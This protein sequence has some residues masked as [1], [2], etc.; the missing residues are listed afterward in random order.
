MA[1]EDSVTESI[2]VSD[3]N[4]NLITLNN[5][6]TLLARTN[7][8]EDEVLRI[9]TATGALD[10]SLMP[11]AG[12]ATDATTDKPY[13]IFY[14]GSTVT[15]TP[16]I[17]SDAGNSIDVGTDG[18]AF[19]SL[20]PA[21]IGDIF[22][23]SGGTASQTITT[24]PFGIGFTD[25]L[26]FWSN[27][28]ISVKTLFTDSIVQIKMEAAISLAGDNL[29]TTD[30]SGLY[31]PPVADVVTTFT[32]PSPGLYRYTNE[33]GAV[34]QLNLN[35][36]SLIAVDTNNILGGGAGASTFV[37]DLLDVISTASLTDTLTSLSYKSSIN[38]LTYTDEYGANTI[39]DLTSG[40][41]TEIQGTNSSVMQTKVTGV[42][43][44]VNPY[45]IETIFKGKMNDLLDVGISAYV[46]GHYIKWTGTKF[47]LAA[48]PATPASS[49][50]YIRDVKLVSNALVFVEG[51]AGDAFSG[52]V[53]L[54]PLIPSGSDSH[55]SLVQL[56]GTDLVFTGVGLGFN[57]SVDV[58]SLVSGGY[59]WNLRDKAG[60]S[61][62]VA[63]ADVVTITSATDLL[64]TSLSA[65]VGPTGWAMN[66]GISGAGADAVNDTLRWDTG[67]SQPY[68]GPAGPTTTP[69]EHFSITEFGRTETLTIK[70]GEV[71]FVVPAY[72]SGKELT[73]FKVTV[74][75]ASV[76][77]AVTGFLWVNGVSYA[78]S[79]PA[80]STFVNV[81]GLAVSLSENDVIYI[82]T[83]A[84]G[85]T[86]AIG[87]NVVGTVE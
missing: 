51:G 21:V 80:A 4:N 64:V 1:C 40:S 82:E 12:I 83:T 38:R 55:I 77:S 47:D 84:V 76:G 46:T 42:G 35:A 32:N 75:T 62:A 60:T 65:T 72:M 85:A 71:F 69:T 30:G 81:S 19:L 8:V 6:D 20:T 44:I 74:I 16:I 43:S 45:T 27:E 5:G 52:S 18:G 48:L 39:I 70:G 73:A 28:T 11:G 79:I 9:S 37:Q 33:V 63:N 66:I 41:A 13:G 68:W 7:N 57:A 59:T 14:N 54:S 86:A 56:V 22:E 53:D 3:I 23:V 50:S 58:S 17:S 67:S 10:I 29:L 15:W 25:R 26:H 24:G 87:L 36:S 49:N 34:A 31:V 2:I 61:A 78:F